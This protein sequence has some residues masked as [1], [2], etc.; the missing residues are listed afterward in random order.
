M[1]IAK[2]KICNLFI[3]LNLTLDDLA[4]TIAPMFDIDIESKTFKKYQ[5][6][7]AASI[8]WNV[9]EARSKGTCEEIWEIAV[10]NMSKSIGKNEILSIQTGFNLA[11]Q[12]AF[13]M[14]GA[15]NKETF[16]VDDRY[17][18]VS[19]WKY[20]KDMLIYHSNTVPEE[21]LKK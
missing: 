15:I 5:Y 12:T 9:N 19:E 18:S 16:I 4:T 20:T 13:N 7:A 11:E 14:W 10:E 21:L 3:G 17:G 8:L 1:M 6:A 2:R